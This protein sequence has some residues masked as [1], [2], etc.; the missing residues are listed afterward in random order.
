MKIAQKL[1]LILLATSLIPLAALGISSLTTSQRAL[2]SEI[3]TSLNNTATH[4]LDRLETINEAVGTRLNN[5]LNK[6]QLRILLNE[7]NA[8]PS[9][10]LQKQLDESLQNIVDNEDTFHTLHILNTAGKVVASTDQSVVGQDYSKKEVFLVGRQKEDTNI[11]FLNGDQDIDQYLAGPLALN[12]NLLGVAIVE[13][14]S[15]PYLAV[16]KD[17]SEL[18][19]TGESYL[20]RK[21]NTGGTEYLTPLRF[22]TKA[23]LTPVARD[24]NSSTDYRKHSVIESQHKIPSTTWT[25]IVKIDQAEVFSALNGQRNI[26]IA[27]IGGC[28]FAALV[29]ALFFARLFTT[30]IIALTKRTNELMNGNFN[31]RITVRSSDEIGSLA[32]SFNTMTARLAESYGALE[33][34][35]VER[36]QA[37]NVKV[38]ELSAAKAKDDAILESIGDGLIVTDNAGYIL[39]I[40]SIAG[41]L[42]GIDSQNVVGKRN[43]DTYQLYDESDQPLPP[44]KR[45][46]QITIATARKTVQVVKSVTSDGSKHVL[47]ITS[48]P[49]LQS[50]EFIG[51]IQTIRDITHEHE[52]DRM[53]SEFISLASHQLRTPLSAIRWFSEMLLTGDAGKL[54]PEQEEFERNISASTQRMIDLVTSLLNISRIE[55]GRII[56]AP[57]PT[58]LAELI[59]GIVSDLKGKTEAKAQNLVISV[60]QGLPKVNIDPHLIGQVYLNLLTNAIKYTPKGGDITVFVSRKDEEIVS[61]VTDTGYGIPKSE[62]GKMFQRFFRAANA[63]KVETDGTGLGMYLVKAIIDSSGGK[64]WF[65]SEEGKGSTFWFS[66]PVAGMKAKAGEVTLDG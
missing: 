28:L 51:T 41:D 3:H 44:E 27:I 4:Q 23:A 6:A 16:T 49:V 25:L 48:T 53:K 57:E 2:K 8:K 33:Q 63:V 12:G 26:A 17:Y 42:L 61:Q 65:E 55:S 43:L 7:Y 18:Q 9:V 46:L 66:L 30:P 47:G 34:K 14:T 40:N 38:H 19:L 64:I 37:L 29:A 35:V 56:I 1:L 22:N 31:E 50:G 52:V 60:N 54:N 59:G 13:A 10:A 39:L 5:V 21:T 32:S 62:Q 20:T 15:A 45:P 24:T 11:F 58:D 36:T